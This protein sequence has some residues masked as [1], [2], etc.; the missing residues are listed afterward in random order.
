MNFKDV[1]KIY[2]KKI[3]GPMVETICGRPPSCGFLTW[4]RKLSVVVLCM[5]VFIRQHLG[6]YT[7]Q[8]VRYGDLFTFVSFVLPL[9]NEPRTWFWPQN[10][11]AACQ[12]VGNVSS[13]FG[14][15]FLSYR[16]VWTVRGRRT[17]GPT[18]GMHCVMWL[19]VGRPHNKTS[20][21]CSSCIVLVNNKCFS[22][23]HHRS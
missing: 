14:L 1:P 18:D 22:I 8:T 20:E 5:S 13:K 16:P 21:C 3:R 23:I 11:I 9:D 4:T 2:N 7:L 17:D 6:A 10:C 15:Y 19:P 12:R